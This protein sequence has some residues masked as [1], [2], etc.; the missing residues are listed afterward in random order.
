VPQTAGKPKIRLR[1]GCA[2]RAADRS[3]PA[4][5]GRVRCRAGRRPASPA[6]APSPPGS[7]PPPPPWDAFAERARE[8]PARAPRPAPPPKPPS[9][10]HPPLLAAPEAA[11]PHSSP[12]WSWYSPRPDPPANGAVEPWFII[13][14]LVIVYL[15]FTSQIHVSWFEFNVIC[16]SNHT[17]KR[18]WLSVWLPQRSP[19]HTQ[20]KYSVYINKLNSSIQLGMCRVPGS[21]PGSFEPG[22]FFWTRTRDFWKLGPG[23]AKF[24]NWDPNPDPHFRFFGPGTSLNT[25]DVPVLIFTVFRFRLLKNRFFGFGYSKISFSVSVLRFQ[26]RRFRFCFRV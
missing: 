25:R 19:S 9:L 5:A 4:G 3:R 21:G 6:P 17:C 8:T 20:C 26:N 16:S 24:E 10:V 12:H 18:V 1:A 13:K 23:P 11:F 22:S 2:A 14:K 15:N 7:S